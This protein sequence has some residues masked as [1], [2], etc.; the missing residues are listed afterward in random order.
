MR[1]SRVDEVFRR[2]AAE[3]GVTR[4]ELLKL[5]ASDVQRRI[6]ARFTN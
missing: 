4:D 1:R 2:L 6:K 3:A 5:D